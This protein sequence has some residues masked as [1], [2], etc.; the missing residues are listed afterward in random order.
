MSL[1]AS[2]SF[3]WWIPVILLSVFV[4]WYF[5]RNNDW[6]QSQKKWIRRILPTLRAIAIF[7]ILTLLLDIV[8]LNTQSDQEKPIV[9][10]LIDVSKS[11]THFKDSA[12]IQNNAKRLIDQVKERFSDKYELAFYTIGSQLK[13]SQDLN[14]NAQKSNHELAFKSLSEQYL[15]RNTG[16]LIFVSDGNYNVGDSPTYAAEQLS[17]TPIYTLGV[18][19]TT[20]KKDQSIQNLYYND[21]VFL[22]DEFPIEVD[23]ETFKIKNTTA[24]L[25]LR[26]NGK[27]LA[28]KTIRY[29]KIGRAHV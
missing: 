2:A 23:I 5:Y 4:A 6:L 14:F 20:P 25:T 3:L 27:T 28:T 24:K 19:D 8:F 1:S 17:L 22:K 26:S 13:N 16:A 9:L 7:C 10:T 12:S 15:N 11:M 29:T 21:I 18:G